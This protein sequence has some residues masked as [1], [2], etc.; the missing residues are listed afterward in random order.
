[1]RVRWPSGVRC[2]RCD[3]DNVHASTHRNMPYRCRSCRRHFSVRIGTPMQSSKIG[4]RNWVFAMFLMAPNLKG[5]CSMHLYRDLG[6]AQSNAWH[7]GHRIRKLWEQQSTVEYFDGPVEFDEAFF[8]GLE[9]N[10]HSNKRLRENWK[11]GKTPVVGARDH[12]SG[13]IRGRVVPDTTREQL[14]D[15]VSRMRTTTRRSS[16]MTSKRIGALCYCSFVRHS[17]GQ[18]VNEQATT[19]GLESFW[20]MLKRGYMGTY[21]RMSPAH[22]QRYVDEFAGR[23]NQRRLDTELRM[24]VMV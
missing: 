2:S 15:W 18:Y 20:A 3:G 13:Q 22:L 21:H 5:T 10:K 4:Y 24:V 8:G 11:S 6:I 1:M 12:T 16:R 14:H 17:V 23:R 19:N 7:L 9:K